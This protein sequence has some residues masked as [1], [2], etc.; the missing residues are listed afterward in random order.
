MRSLRDTTHALDAG[1]AR[2]RQQYSVPDG[3]PPDVLAAA[4]A[5]SKK[6]PTAHVDRTD[7]DFVTLD[8]ASSTDLDQ[9]FTISRSGSDL[10]LHYA[11]ADVAWFV[12]DGDVVDAE[13]W[14]RG[15]TL[16]LPDGRETLYPAVLSEGAVSLLPDGPR[17]AVVF[18][19]R[20]DTEGRPS[21]D[22]VERCIIRNRAKLGYETVTLADLPADFAEFAERVERNESARGAGRVDPPEQLVE[23]EGRGY[24]LVFRPRQPTEAQNAA[25]SASTNIAVAE[26][27]Q[28]ACTG[29]FR[30]MP[31]PDQRAVA[32]LRLTANA[33]G[34]RWP[35]HQPLDEYARTL[36][37]NDPRHAAFMLA[38]RRAGG[39][40]S[41]A[42][43]SPDVVP[44]HAAL[45]ATYAHSTAPLRRLA[46]RYVIECALAVANGREVP[47]SV[48][49]AL[50]RLPEAMAAATAQSSKVDRA[51]VDLAEAVLLQGHEGHTFRAVVVEDEGDVSRIQLIDIA[52]VAKLRAAKL[53]PG[54]E[55]RVK[56]VRA[57]PVRREVEFTRV[58]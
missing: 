15:S 18:H 44:W 6:E 5:A 24:R 58:A 45:A 35:K 10:L 31:A 7:W 12:S 13:A 23:R 46:D 49:A 39:G 14:R 2:I 20:L 37:P 28:A 34:M 53:Q 50:P 3:F 40:A 57:D 25:L 1:L 38:V 26:A 42:T 43:Y 33:F 56:L 51:V 36:D 22:G 16:Y 9:A 55:C 17:P 8:P 48:Q 32:R 21:L 11:I 19:V 41:Y 30:V 52:V 47:E 27:L 29:L 54:D 4:D